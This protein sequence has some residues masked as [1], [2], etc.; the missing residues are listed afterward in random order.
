MY[1]DDIVSRKQDEYL[2][3]KYFQ[4][5]DKAKEKMIVFHGE[6][7]TACCLKDERKRPVRRLQNLWLTFDENPG[8][9]I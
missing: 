6:K 5:C 9:E 2:S 8:D 3:L 1:I 4:S 7:G